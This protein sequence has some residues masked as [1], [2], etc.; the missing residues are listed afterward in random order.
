MAGTPDKVRDLLMAVWEP[1]KAAADGDATVLQAMM[2]DDGIDADL[3][4]W[5]WRYYAEKRRTAEHDL[6]EAAN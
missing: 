4:P 2:A 6:D 3:A 5:D 1:A